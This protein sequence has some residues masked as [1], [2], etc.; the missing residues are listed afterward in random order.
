MGTW[1]GI[2]AEGCAWRVWSWSSSSARRC[3]S[4]RELARRLGVAEPLVLLVLGA[5]L[6]FIPYLSDVQ[7]PPDVVLLLFLPALLYWESLNTSLREIRS[8][9]RSI[10]LQSVGLVFATAAVVAV[11]GHA[12]GLP[13]MIALALG[14]ILAPT[15]ATAVGIVAGRLPRRALTMLRAESLI[16]DGTALVLYAVAV[17]AVVAQ[18]HIDLGDT[19]LRFLGS[20]GFGIAIGLAVGLLAVAVRRQLN[21]PVL[22]NTMSVLTPFLAYLPAELVHASGV[23]AVVTCGLTMSQVGPKVISAR[24]RTQAFAFWQITTHILNGALFV[25]IG[26]QLHAV[27]D[28][29]NASTW[30]RTMLL[31][32][33][34]TVGVIGTRLVWFYTVP[35]LLR[36]VDRRPAQRLRRVSARHRLPLAWAGFRGAVSLAAALALPLETESGAPLP[37]REI[38]IAVTFGVILFTLLAQGLTIPAV[39]RWAEMPPD[40]EEFREEALAEQKALK[41]ALDALPEVAEE[42]GTPMEAQNAC[43]ARLSGSCG[44]SRPPPIPNR[45]NTSRR[46]STTSRRSGWRSCRSSGRRSSGSGTRTSSTTWCCGGCRPG[47][48]PTRCG[49]RAWRTASD[50]AVRG[51]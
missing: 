27:T 14:A 39:V 11:I 25:L 6:G 4:A 41:A 48:T 28:V 20:Y 46:S 2:A 17:G 23:V 16:N 22:E 18:Q 1:A 9:L 26:F 51:R 32:L 43:V 33:L 38:V 21:A 45:P 8:N 19:V 29:F 31:G 13:V 49:S 50:L 40:P 3:S 24:T 15:D 35:Y 47:S 12:F 5:V 37:D 36:M 10:L 7:L 34:V 30:E 42:L 44:A